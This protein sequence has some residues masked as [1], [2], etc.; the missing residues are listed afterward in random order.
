M[1]DR[2]GRELYSLQDSC[3]YQT[4]DSF[5]S[6]TDITHMASTPDQNLPIEVRLERI[7]SALAHLQ[8]DVDDLNSALVGYFRR[9]QEIDR[10]FI[11]LEHELQT[12]GDPAERADA[13]TERPPHY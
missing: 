7:E 12:F 5:V 1:I 4:R 9:L 11:R 6:V 3:E 2:E 8:H 10:R 13:E